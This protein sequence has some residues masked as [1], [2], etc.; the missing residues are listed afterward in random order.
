MIQ[1]DFKNF[2]S[3]NTCKVPDTQE[4]PSKQCLFKS[5]AVNAQLPEMSVEEEDWKRKSP[6][7]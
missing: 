5:I 1:E 3:G 2:R 6:D 7:G 4:V